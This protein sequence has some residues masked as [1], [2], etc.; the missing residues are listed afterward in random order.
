MPGHQ[1]ATSQGGV[2]AGVAVIARS[3]KTAQGPANSPPV[4]PTTMPTPQFNAGTPGLY[5][6]SGTYQSNGIPNDVDGDIL[7]LTKN[8]VVMQ[9]LSWDGGRFVYD[10]S[11]SGQTLGGHILTADD[12]HGHIVPSPAF[13]IVIATTAP[14]WAGQPT[15]LFI[16]GSTQPYDLAWA[17]GNFNPATDTVVI[18]SGGVPWL[19]AFGTQLVPDGTQ[20]TSSGFTGLVVGVQRSGSVFAEINLTVTVVA[21]GSG[22]ATWMDWGEFTYGYSA[23]QAAVGNPVVANALGTWT[24]PAQPSLANEAEW[25][26]NNARQSDLSQP[27]RLITPVWGGFYMNVWDEEAPLIC[28]VPG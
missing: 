8:T 18:I 16:A 27:V 19:A 24:Y 28:V 5:P 6:P 23:E 12:Q 14:Y 15:P 25:Q 7:I 13:S 26:T 21:A 20:T 11:G 22:V 1:I 9:G 17:I 3:N 4:W 10:G 2:L